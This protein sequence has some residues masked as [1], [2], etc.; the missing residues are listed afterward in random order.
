MH[1]RRPSI[2]GT[3]TLAGNTYRNSIEA[4]RAV[5]K[6]TAVQAFS[7]AP[8]GMSSSTMSQISVNMQQSILFSAEKYRDQIIAP[9][10]FERVY[11]MSIDPREWPHDD[12]L[13]R[14][15]LLI[16]EPHPLSHMLVTI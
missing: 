2:G 1:W 13:A 16:A 6:T 3:V 8:S 12:L 9:H 14:W 10:L 15:H 11:C 5:L 7:S 4:S